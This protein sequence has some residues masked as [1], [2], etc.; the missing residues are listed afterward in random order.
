MIDST[1]IRFVAWREVIQI[2]Y[3]SHRK[4]ES[5]FLWLSFIDSMTDFVLAG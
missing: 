3:E 2:K 1:L 4:L 5:N